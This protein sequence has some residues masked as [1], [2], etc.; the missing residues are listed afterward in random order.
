MYMKRHLRC[1]KFE[2]TTTPKTT[3]MLLYIIVFVLGGGPVGPLKQN[4]TQWLL[5]SASIK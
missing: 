4:H 1:M 3:I 5:L 2:R